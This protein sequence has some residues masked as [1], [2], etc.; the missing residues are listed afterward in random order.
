VTF[1]SIFSIFSLNSY[2]VYAATSKGTTGFAT[3]TGFAT[4]S[5]FYTDSFYFS[6][7]A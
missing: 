3:A 2:F 1:S 5:F 7:T 4:S 6:K